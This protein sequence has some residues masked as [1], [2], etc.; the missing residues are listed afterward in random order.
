MTKLKGGDDARRW[1]SA[2]AVLA[3]LIAGLAPLLLAQTVRAE[4]KKPV[5]AWKNIT[6][7]YTT[8]IKGKI[9]PCG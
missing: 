4:D 5:K 2:F 3:V 7:L 1:V 8:D 9:E 6:M